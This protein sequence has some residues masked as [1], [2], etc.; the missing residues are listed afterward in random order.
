MTGIVVMFTHVCLLE[1]DYHGSSRISCSWKF[2]DWD[3]IGGNI[4]LHFM[5]DCPRFVVMLSERRTVSCDLKNTLR[6]S[7]NLLKAL[8]WSIKF[9]KH[10]RLVAGAEPRLRNGH[11]WGG[12]QHCGSS[13]EAA[14]RS[15][16]LI[17][18]VRIVNEQR[19]HVDRRM[20]GNHNRLCRKTFICFKFL[21]SVPLIFMLLK[22]KVYSI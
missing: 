12:E 13:N 14:P 16:F 21:A 8:E 2:R 5:S 3:S 10:P 17:A 20:A 6:S 18:S 15:T 19:K 9:G 7:W 4:W 22:W 11:Y 1:Y